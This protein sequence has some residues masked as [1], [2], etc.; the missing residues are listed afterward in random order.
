MACED[1]VQFYECEFGC[2]EVVAWKSGST[3]GDVSTGNDRYEDIWETQE[4]C[5]GNEV[6]MKFVCQ[7]L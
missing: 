5:Y 3:D 7:E 2:E 6:F 4:I 1:D